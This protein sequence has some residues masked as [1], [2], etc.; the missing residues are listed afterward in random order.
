MKDIEK[1]LADVL[2]TIESLKE[3]VVSIQKEVKPKELFKW[4]WNPKSNSAYYFVDNS[5]HSTNGIRCH[6]GS[7]K[8]DDCT[9]KATDEE[10]INTLAPIVRE[11]GLIPGV[12]IKKPEDWGRG[13]ES[14]L[15][16]TKP[17]LNLS[18]E[19]LVVG[20][21]FVYHFRS[22]TWAEVVKEENWKKVG[23][24]IWSYSSNDPKDCKAFL[25]VSSNQFDYCCGLG[26]VCSDRATRI[27]TEEEIKIELIKA[28][29][30]K[31]FKDGVTV[32]RPSIWE[33]GNNIKITITSDYFDMSTNS[34]G[35]K[36]LRLGTYFI[37]SFDDNVW[38]EVVKEEPLVFGGYKVEKTIFANN[39]LGFK[40]GC[41]QFTLRLVKEMIVFMEENDIHQITVKGEFV[42]LD[43]LKKITML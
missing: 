1:K 17:S 42:T 36:Y 40:V 25:I 7:V 20:G 14:K 16:V 5:D 12:T 23:T 33:I 4:Y 37:Y 10:I 32:R 6:A 18:G 38:A 29:R 35:H 9:R 43:Q 21:C 41:T 39:D 34:R 19:Y 24:W 8:G 15:G 2:N 30:K 11:K 3:V 13:V 22:N 28:A 27:A 31:G 26:S